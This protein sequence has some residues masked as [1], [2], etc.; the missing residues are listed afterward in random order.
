MA[1][2]N[3]NQRRHDR[4]SDRDW[5]EW[6]DQSNEWN[7]RNWNQNRNYEDD[8]NRSNFN[9]SGARFN[10]GFN[11]S[12]LNRGPSNQ[13]GNYG[14]YRSTHDDR[15]SSSYFGNRS[16]PYGNYEM[17]NRGYQEYSNPEYERFGGTTNQFDQSRNRFDFDRQQ[18]EGR[19]RWPM[20]Q[21]TFGQRSGREFEMN[22]NKPG[23][24]RGKG[25]RG[26]SRSDER[27][28]EDINDRLSDNPFIDATEIEVMVS[29]GEVTLTGSVT[30]RNDK[31]MA[32]DIAESVSGVKNVENR[33]RVTAIRDKE[34]GTSM[35]TEKGS[36]TP[37]TEREKSRTKSNHFVES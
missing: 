13:W 36:K 22:T 37:P 35:E 27:I 26:Y 11:E 14:N 20:S 6:N 18:Q 19:S 4:N 29:G 30:D 33:I 15:N 7:D 5:N 23:E 34:M 12:R 1:N 25:P 21:E 24:H 31:R 28:K 32:E 10:R 2:S 8:Y 9:D 17:E 16:Y 3:R